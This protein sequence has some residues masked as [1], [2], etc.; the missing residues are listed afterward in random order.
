MGT[1]PLFDCRCGRIK[2]GFEVTEHRN[3]NPDC[4][5]HGATSDWYRSPEQTAKRDAQRERL[6]ELQRLSPARKPLD[7]ATT[8]R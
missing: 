8:A 3:W 5:E 4:P 1:E 7:N 6:T 2:I